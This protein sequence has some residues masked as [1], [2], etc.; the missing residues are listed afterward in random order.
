MLHNQPQGW[1]TFIR[2][3]ALVWC[4]GA[5]LL[6]QFQQHF[7]HQLIHTHEHEAHHSAADEADECH[8]SIFHAGAPNACDHPTHLSQIHQDCDWCDFFLYSF[9]RTSPKKPIAKLQ[10]ISS[11]V[12]VY[13]PLATLSSWECTRSRAPPK[14]V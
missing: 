1:R 13:T 2:Y 9:W 8:V 14:L 7:Q 12:F 10:P 5:F 4:L 11:E 3:T 6:S